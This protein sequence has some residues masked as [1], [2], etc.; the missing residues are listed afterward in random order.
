MQIDF[1]D[2]W[3]VCVFRKRFIARGFRIFPTI[4]TNLFLLQALICYFLHLLNE[5]NI[6]NI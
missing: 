1:V 6:A 4:Y 5:Q 2:N 3:I